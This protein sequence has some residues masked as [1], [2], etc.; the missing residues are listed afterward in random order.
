MNGE[1]EFIL[2]GNE[3]NSIVSIRDDELHHLGNGN[4]SIQRR[5]TIGQFSH[6]KRINL[7]FSAKYNF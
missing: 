7:S 3:L 1:E 5:P 4:G 6:N 2:F